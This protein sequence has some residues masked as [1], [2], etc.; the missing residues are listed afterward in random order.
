MSQQSNCYHYQY[1]LCDSLG[2]SFTNN[3]KFLLP[4]NQIYDKSYYS[5]I[6]PV[7][8]YKFVKPGNFP[9]INNPKS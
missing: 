4:S 7:Q 6:Y 1:Q 5:Y 9:N 8:N 2:N 3:K